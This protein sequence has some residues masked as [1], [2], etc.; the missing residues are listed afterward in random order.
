MYTNKLAKYKVGKCA[1]N[2]S[3]S[4]YYERD[5]IIQKL[6]RR[7]GATFKGIYIS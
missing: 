4:Y 5:K 7:E 3:E 2:V 1:F 6:T